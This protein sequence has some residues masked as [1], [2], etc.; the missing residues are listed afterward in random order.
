MPSTGTYNTPTPSGMTANVYYHYGNDPGPLDAPNL[1]Y[2]PQY[3]SIGTSFE[4]YPGTM[5]PADLAPTQNGAAI[6]APGAMFN[7]LALCAQP[8][9][10]PSSISGR[11]AR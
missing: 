10:A 2:N 1:D 9:T 6:W 3:R 8:D 5:I 7:G 4:I 11:A